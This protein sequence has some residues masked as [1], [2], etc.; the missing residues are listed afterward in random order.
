MT[1][2]TS[3]EYNAQCLRWN[4]SR[5]ELALKYFHSADTK[6]EDAIRDM[7]KDIHVTKCNSFMQGIDDAIKSGEL[8]RVGHGVYRKV[9][10]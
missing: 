7:E 1:D 8:I 4:M 6:L 2:G 9:R 10:K 3:S 5:S